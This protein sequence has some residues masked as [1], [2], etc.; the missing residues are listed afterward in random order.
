MTAITDSKYDGQRALSR[1]RHLG[2]HTVA[3]FSEKYYFAS[4][5][6]LFM[7][8]WSIFLKEARIFRFDPSDS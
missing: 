1:L 7:K 2:C 5:G 3:M 8:R 6:K 4:G